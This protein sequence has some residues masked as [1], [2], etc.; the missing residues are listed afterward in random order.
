MASNSSDL[1][2]L[3]PRLAVILRGAQ[4]AAV[5]LVVGGLVGELASVT[6]ALLEMAGVA[7]LVASPFV[8]TVVIASAAG[9]SSRRLLAFAVVT[10][11]LAGLGIVIAA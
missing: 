11:V 6:G 2:T 3:G 1:E 8:A 4:W 7:V 5:A 10:L 9:R